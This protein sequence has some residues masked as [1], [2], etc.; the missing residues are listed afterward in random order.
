MRKS[1]TLVTRVPFQGGPGSF[2]INPPEGTHPLL[3][4]V[5]PKSGGRQG[6]KI[7]RKFQ[8]LLN[9]RQ[10][11]QVAP[12]HLGRYKKVQNLRLQVYNLSKGGPSPG[13]QMF[14]EVPNVRIVVCGGD[15]TV[16][17]VLDALGTYMVS[18]ASPTAAT[19][20]YRV[21]S[22]AKM[23]AWLLGSIPLFYG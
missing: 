6:A 8:Y 1:G 22:Y 5:N 23:S 20:S 13:L 19:P 16:G 21:Q 15:G 4:F 18:R 17:W 14:R 3:V 9:P 11:I 7:L 10:V 12:H 2:Q